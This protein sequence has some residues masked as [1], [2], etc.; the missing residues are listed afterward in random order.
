MPAGLLIE[1]AIAG[2]ITDDHLVDVIRNKDLDALTHIGK[3]EES[4]MN[5]F[6]YAQMNWEDVVQ[7]I[8]DGYTFKFITIRGLLNLIQTK[9]SFTEN[10]DFII[11]DSQINLRLTDEQLHFL[12]SRIPSQWEFIKVEHKSYN[13]CAILAQTHQIKS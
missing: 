2:G 11:N 9:F 7:A 12:N 3:K 6:E 8:H 5:F 10:V 1:A 13:Y 4:W